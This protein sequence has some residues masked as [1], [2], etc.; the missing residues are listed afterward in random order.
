[1]IKS[2]LCNISEFILLIFMRNKVLAREADADKFY[3]LPVVNHEY[4]VIRAPA[5]ISA[6]IFNHPRMTSH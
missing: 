5:E 4:V 2:L 1:M 3:D 6:L